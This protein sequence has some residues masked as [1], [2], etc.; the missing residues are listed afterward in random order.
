MNEVHKLAVTALAEVVKN[1][2]KP[3]TIWK[4]SPLERWG[5]E[6]IDTRGTAGELLVV[7]LLEAGGRKPD[8]QKD[9]THTDK[10][11]DFMCNG[12]RYEVKAARI[13][14]TTRKFQHENIYKTRHYDGIILVDIAPNEIYISCWAKVDIPFDKETER[15][16]HAPKGAQRSYTLHRR[17]DSSFYKW[18]TGIT[19]DRHIKQG[20]RVKFCVRD[21][22]V[23]SVKDFM[24]EFKKME[25][26]IRATR[27]KNPAA[28]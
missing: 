7:K 24:K 27:S 18:D 13:G 3:V 19:S 9:T 6:E 5:S 10:D 16:G 21:H 26:R 20:K 17:K 25:A 1:R 2:K 28:L 15:G 12:L 14:T 11:W 23:R 4:G 8:Y 22:A